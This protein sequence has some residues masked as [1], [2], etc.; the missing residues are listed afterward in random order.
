[1][2]AIE[3]AMRTPLRRQ[4]HHSLAGWQ[5]HAPPVLAG[6]KARIDHFAGFL[7]SATSDAL[8]KNGIGG[9]KQLLPGFVA[10]GRGV[11]ERGKTLRPEL[12]YGVCSEGLDP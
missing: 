4:A 11:P 2:S 6:K 3:V 7:K 10:H 8:K 12:L 9:G 5:Y 1:M